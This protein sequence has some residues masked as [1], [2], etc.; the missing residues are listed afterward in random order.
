MGLLSSMHLLGRTKDL[1]IYCPKQL[2]DIIDIHLGASNARFSYSFAYHFLE[3]KES[4]KI[5]EEKGLEIHT[6]PL[7]H[8][9]LT[10]GFLFKEQPQPRKMKAQMIDFYEIPHYKINQIKMGDDFIDKEGNVISN[11]QLTFPAPKSRSYAFCSDTAYYEKIIPIISHV[12]L[13]Y[14]EATFLEDEAHLAKKTFHST[15]KQAST[16]ALKANVGKLLIGHFSARYTQ[17]HYLNFL[18]EG[19]TVFENIII[20]KEQET[21]SL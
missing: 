18:Q 10:N 19:K 8:K 20:S 2:K 14:H 5:Y 4:E 12:D 3:S 11:N 15:V 21:Y 7:K 17:E 9:I 16:I 1:H 13:L 6:I